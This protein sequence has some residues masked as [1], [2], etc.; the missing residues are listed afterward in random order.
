MFFDILGYITIIMGLIFM[1]FG[2]LGV[3]GSKTFNKTILAA[4]MVDSVGFFTVLLG[5]CFLKGLSFFTLK[6]LLLISIGLLINPITTHIILR[7]AHLA[8]HKEE[9]VDD[10]LNESSN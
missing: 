5:I 10:E 6:T 9:V 8:G 2:F 4:S 3:F 7:S 1:L